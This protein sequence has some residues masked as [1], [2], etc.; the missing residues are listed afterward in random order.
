M[1]L[2]IKDPSG[3]QKYL[4]WAAKRLDTLEGTAGPATA[5]YVS[6]KPRTISQVVGSHS[7]R[8]QRYQ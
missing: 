3:N 2:L 1:L 8:V 5:E 7:S 6:H 4:A